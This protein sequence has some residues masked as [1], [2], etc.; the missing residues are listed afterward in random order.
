MH[1]FV[2]TNAMQDAEFSLLAGVDLKRKWIAD[3]DAHLSVEK[4]TRL[5]VLRGI[6]AAAVANGLDLLRTVMSQNPLNV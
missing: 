2:D 1:P 6:R 4:D 3:K 5:R